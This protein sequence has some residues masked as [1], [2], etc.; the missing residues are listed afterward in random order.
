MFVEEVVPYQDCRGRAVVVEN[1]KKS[2]FWEQAPIRS[3][4][5]SAATVDMCAYGKRR[6]D[7][8][9]LVK[10]PTMFKGTAT[11]CEM[12]AVTCNGNHE[13]GQVMGAW[14]GKGCADPEGKHTVCECMGR[15]LH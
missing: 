1:P 11:V 12:I 9:Q 4:L 7:T 13:H 5:S 6:P 15:W 3:A 10:K 14:K 8:N 2:L